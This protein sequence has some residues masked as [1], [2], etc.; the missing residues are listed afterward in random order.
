MNDMNESKIVAALSEIMA[1][2]C[3]IPSDTAKRFR[4]LGAIHDIGKIMLPFE[5]LNKPGKLN[6]QETELIKTHTKLG[7]ELLA[8]IQGEIGE[9]ARSVCLLHHEWYDGSKS[10]WG[11]LSSELPVYIPVVSI[12]DVAVALLSKRSYKQSWTLEETLE[13]IRAR[14]GTQF[15]PM[16][17][18]IF[19]ELMRND[20]SVNILFAN[21]NIKLP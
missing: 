12:C 8:D 2:K 21:Y 10:Y 16:L 17:T 19:L 5:I 14:S 13:Y 11:K 4:I 18:E 9:M 3:G 7:A 20:E 1:K 6:H 15:S